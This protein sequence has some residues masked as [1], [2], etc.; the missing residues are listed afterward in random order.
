[1]HAGLPVF[2]CCCLENPVPFYG[3]CHCAR[4]TA[5]A[6]AGAPTIYLEGLANS[7]FL[8]V[9]CSNFRRRPMRTEAAE[10]NSSNSNSRTW[11][12]R[13]PRPRHSSSNSFTSSCSPRSSLRLPSP[14]SSP[15]R[16]LLQRPTSSSSSL[17]C[18]NRRRCCPFPRAASESRWLARR[19]TNS[20]SC[21]SRPRLHP[22]TPPS[23]RRR[24]RRC[25]GSRQCNSSSSS[26]S[27][28]SSS[29]SRCPLHLRCRSCRSTWRLPPQPRRPLN[30]S[31]SRRPLKTSRRLPTKKRS[32]TVS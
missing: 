31:N 18:S 14:S 12:M 17:N 3:G 7:V 22:R 4:N 8:Y 19:R 9:L 10:R 28:S 30:R 5:T 25:P 26:S 32:R 6:A 11:P 13:P 20:S 15:S 2:F 27:N 16:L 23:S 24:L 29:F 21:G 1:M